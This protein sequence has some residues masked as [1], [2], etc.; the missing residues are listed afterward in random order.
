MTTDAPALKPARFD[1][2]WLPL[3]VTTI[4]SF[5][6]VL[7]TS[8]VNIALPSI[9]KDFGATLQDGQLV[10]TSYLMALAVV[11]PTTGFMA[12]R[13]GMK[14]LYII[15]LAC[16]TGGSALCGFAW[17]IDSLIFFRVLQG[18]GGGMIQPLGMALVFTMITPLERPYFM[19]LLGIP[20][21]L[22]PILG[23]SLGGYLTEYSSWRAIFLVNI[24]IGLIDIVLAM[25]LLKET[26]I[27]SAAKLD[28]RG[29]VLSAITFPSLV[30]ALSWGADHGW[31]SPLVLALLVIGAVGFVLFVRA[32][33]RHHDPMLQLR[34]FKN[35]MFRLSVGIQW[36]GFFSLFGLNFILPLYLQFAHGWGAAK[37]GVALL[38]MGA[39]A[40][41]T[42]NLA[43]RAYN[44]VGPRILAVAGLA[45]LLLTTLLWSFVDEQT[46]MW[47]IMILVGGRGLAL[48]MFSQTVQ[49]VAYNTVPDGQMPRA[50]ALVN[51]TQRINGA[52][53]TAILTT[54]LVI[55]LQLHNAPS[56]TSIT[57]GTVSLDL[58]LD[59]FRDAFWVMSGVSVI[60][61]IMSFFLRDRLL[62][63][64]KARGGRGRP[65]PAAVA[66][67]RQE[68]RREPA[69]EAT[70][71]I[72]TQQSGR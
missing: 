40:F 33:L 48:G 61:L 11:I 72:S 27:R 1:P 43:G 47:A 34:L 41:V 37:T 68:P 67:I 36:V 52:V 2:R 28:M 24:P 17:N 12:E 8:I 38:P 32:E 31:D 63:E 66:T 23:P 21:L 15:T 35:A 49:M 69:A 5:M 3:A 16:F 45:T 65:T 64:F 13:I 70:Q 54:I 18:L 26:P 25:I 9:L 29:F 62:E 42:M 4:G 59:A 60:G 50:T 7:D 44:R 10:I 19:G 30:F 58:M 56:G 20:V 71:A 6:S 39:V 57:D 14:R 46:T 51:V 55:S 22:G 53:S